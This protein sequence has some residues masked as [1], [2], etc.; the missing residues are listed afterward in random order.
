M[1][2][3]RDVAPGATRSADGRTLITYAMLVADWFCE[4]DHIDAIQEDQLVTTDR[5]TTGTPPTGDPARATHSRGSDFLQLDPAAAPP[6]GLTDWLVDHV[7]TAI[8]DGR[9]A[10]GS[11]LPPSR[12]LASDLAVSRGVVVQAY[13]RLHDEGLTDTRPGSGTVVTAPPARATAQT[14]ASATILGAGR[15][16]PPLP[17]LPRQAPPGVLDLSPGVPDLSA[18]PRSDWLRAERAA[19]DS[20]TGADLGY[21]D[22]RG[23]PSLR[24]VLAG[25]LARTRGIRADPGAIVV[26]AGVAQALG[27]LAHVLARRGVVDV[28]V[29]DPGSRGARDQLAYWGMRPV[30]IE[31]DENGLRV[32]ELWS[33]A[34][35]VAVLTPA[36]QFPT[37]VVLHPD[38]RRRARRLGGPRRPRDRG[39][40]R[41]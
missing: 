6:H 39:R 8:A 25:W 21:G 23:S 35:D 12:T 32:S 36:H 7:R 10:G 28:A 27:L 41:R 26:V 15:D 16:E 4:K 14:S 2:Q 24:A 17:L 38:R 20:A 37:G 22:P 9:L 29:E 30:G 19:L 5:G 31:V 33:G 13:Q 1:N 40:L 34:S 11:R 3:K 18:F